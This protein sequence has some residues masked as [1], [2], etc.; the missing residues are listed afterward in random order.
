MGIE[1]LPLARC[2][3]NGAWLTVDADRCDAL[4]VWINELHYQNAGT[5][6]GEAVELVGPAGLELAGWSV[7]A[8]NGNNGAV[9][10]R[11]TFGAADRLVAG[12]AAAGW[13]FAVATFV[14]LQNGP[15]AVGLVTPAGNVL[16]LLSY[17]GS[18]FVVT[19]GA[20]S[21]LTTVDIGATEASA[22]A[23]GGSLETT[24]GGTGQSDP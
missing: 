5:D 3:G 16:Q 8:I 13:G 14:A 17:G 6:V 12:G 21:G 22:A 4:E 7:E 9:Y 24:G 15:D 2:G 23:A 18:P 11:H 1:L 10:G 19:N 20:A